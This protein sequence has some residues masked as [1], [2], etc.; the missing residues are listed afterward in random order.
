MPSE[1]FNGLQVGE[2]P[3][4]VAEVGSNHNGDMMLAR[5]LVDAAKACG[6]DAV[7]FQSWSPESLISRIE[8]DRN[9]QYADSPKKHF[10]SLRAMTERYYLRPDQH[11]ELADYCRAVGIEFCSSHFSAAEADLLAS[12]GVRFFKLASMDITNHRLLRYTAS[13]GKPIILSTGMASLGEIESAVKAIEDE[14]QREIILLHCISIYPPRLED[15]NLRNMATLAAAFGYPV[16]LS[17][18]SIGDAVAIGSV[19]L[20]SV[21]IEKHFTLDK[22]LPGWDHE[23]SADPAEMSRLVDSCRTVIRALGSAKRVVSP[24]EQA[25]RVKFRRSVVTTKR[26]PKGHV[27]QESDLDAKRPGDGIP[28]DQIDMVIG[29]TLRRDMQDD[30]QILWNDLG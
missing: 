19:A 17:D 30:E 11:H 28:P 9:Q 18:H 12:L 8:Y 2:A 4:I 5:Q 16:G 26:L 1:F 14:G 21:M 3:F 25:K 24:Q 20:G 22:Q 23:I 7:K 15:I 27:L 6:C 10:G 13:L 29:R